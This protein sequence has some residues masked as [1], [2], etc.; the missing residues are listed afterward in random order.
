MSDAKPYTSEDV[1]AWV[2]MRWER[3]RLD[4][5]VMARIRAT[6][7]ERDGLKA[8]VEAVRALCRDQLDHGKV[9]ADD[10]AGRIIDAMDEATQ[11]INDDQNS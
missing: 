6:V 3:E 8:Q 10:L 7:E 2:E 5:K 1:R 11:D 9:E 4:E